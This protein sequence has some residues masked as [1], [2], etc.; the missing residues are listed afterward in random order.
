M[1]EPGCAAAPWS[2]LIIKSAN[3]YT[4]SRTAYNLRRPTGCY[5][6][7]FF[8]TR[9]M[10]LFWPFFELMRNRGVVDSIVWQVDAFPTWACMNHDVLWCVHILSWCV[11]LT[12]WCV[13]YV[14]ALYGVSCWCDSK[15]L[16]MRSFGLL[17]W[18][19]C[20]LMCTAPVNID[21]FQLANG[22]RLR[23]WRTTFFKIRGHFRGP[24]RS[25]HVGKKWISLDF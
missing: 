5:R 21:A 12:R 14:F 9:L 2:F 7:D 10:C 6:I 4:L 13:R 8:T 16:L 11:G 24:S 3:S 15:L 23:T 19:D 25:T 18:S 1:A 22:E 20:V 17:M